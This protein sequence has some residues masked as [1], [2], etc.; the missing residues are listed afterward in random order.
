MSHAVKGSLALYTILDGAWAGTTWSCLVTEVEL[1][2]RWA[3]IIFDGC[4]T[5]EGCA[6]V[7]PEIGHSRAMVAYGQLKP[8][9]A[10]PDD[11]AKR[12]VWEAKMAAHVAEQKAIQAAAH[13]AKMESYSHF[14]VG[15]TVSWRH[16]IGGG[17]CGQPECYLP[18]TGTIMSIDLHALKVV[19]KGRASLPHLKREEELITTGLAVLSPQD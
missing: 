13:A 12:A 18:Y 9:E 1:T 5:P 17:G 7:W 6:A 4:V 2:Q 8:R 15:Q 14:R 16:L 10:S 3:W 11:G 19:I